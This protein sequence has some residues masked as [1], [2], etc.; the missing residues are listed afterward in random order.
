MMACEPNLKSGCFVTEQCERLPGHT[1]RDRQDR[2]ELT[3]TKGMKPYV[4]LAHSSGAV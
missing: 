4:G 1:A 2:G 3:S